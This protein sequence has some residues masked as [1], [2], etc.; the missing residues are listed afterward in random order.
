MRLA[1][2]QQA[3]SDPNIQGLPA[4]T[5]EDR[6]GLEK[7][8]PDFDPR[9][10]RTIDARSMQDVAKA[11]QARIDAHP[12][13]SGQGAAYKSILPNLG[14]ETLAFWRAFAENTLETGDTD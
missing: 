7:Y 8:H 4:I 6:H 12:T 11:I 5:M 2:K 13:K 1:A 3:T 14:W 10:T 9:A